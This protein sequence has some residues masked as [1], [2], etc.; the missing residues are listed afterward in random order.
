[1]K[2]QPKKNNVFIACLIVGFFVLI[3]AF[4]IKKNEDKNKKYSNWPSTEG[5]V[6]KYTRSSTS[7]GILE[8]KRLILRY[9]KK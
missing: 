4:V 6:T 1:M 5:I 3:P 7:N 9:L 2:K 8:V